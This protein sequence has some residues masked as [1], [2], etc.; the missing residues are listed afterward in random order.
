MCLECTVMLPNT[1]ESQT[2]TLSEIDHEISDLQTEKYI[3][4]GETD[5]V[6]K[7][8]LHSTESQSL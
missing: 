7:A 5:K 3:R 2:A 6:K 1:V 8:F 4:K